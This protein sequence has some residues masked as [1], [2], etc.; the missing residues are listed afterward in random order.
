LVVGLVDQPYRRYPDPPVDSQLLLD[1]NCT[2][3][4]LSSR[5]SFNLR[6]ERPRPS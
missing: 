3:P 6:L 4:D 5:Y 2:P 1:A